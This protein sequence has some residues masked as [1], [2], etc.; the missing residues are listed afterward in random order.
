M[1]LNMQFA[2]GAF[3][4]LAVTVSSCDTFKDEITPESYSETAKHL[5]G[6]WQLTTVFRNGINITKNMDFSRFHILL[7]KDNT[8]EMK[9]YLPFIVKDNGT[10]NVDDPFFPFHLSFKEEGANEEMKTEIGFLTVDGERRLT[11]NLSPGCHTNKYVYTFKQ[12]TE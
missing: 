5:D 2:I 7:K 8:Y 6:N 9:N 4:A 3:F 1:K 11:I 10:W 12:V